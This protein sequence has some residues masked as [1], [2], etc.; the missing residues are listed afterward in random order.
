LRPIEEV[1]V[2]IEP[3]YDLGFKG[4]VTAPDGTVKY[5]PYSSFPPNAKPY[6]LKDS[7]QKAVFHFMKLLAA[8]LKCTFERLFDLDAFI[9]ATSLTRG[10]VPSSSRG[11]RPVDLYDNEHFVTHVIMNMRMGFWHVLHALV[12]I[13]RQWVPKSWGWVLMTP[14]RSRASST[15]VRTLVGLYIEKIYSF[16]APEKMSKEGL[17]NVIQQMNGIEAFFTATVRKNMA[18]D[19]VDGMRTDLPLDVYKVSV[20]NALEVQTR[21]L[22]S[23]I[24]VDTYETLTTLASDMPAFRMRN[25]KNP[26]FTVREYDTHLENALAKVAPLLAKER[27]IAGI[28]PSLTA[29]P[30]AERLV[31]SMKIIKLRHLIYCLHVMTTRISGYATRPGT[32]ALVSS[33]D[34]LVVS[35]ASELNSIPYLTNDQLRQR[36]QSLVEVEEED[37]EDV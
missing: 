17:H 9:T 26:I 27:T 7:S 37:Q 22:D 12:M 33:L 13:T 29:L 16:N 21:W 8:D 5:Q 14:L 4:K 1:T 20:A 25:A 34:A 19:F 30:L 36:R 6:V 3:E 2:K 24:V 23:K 18:D 35:V 11:A 32:I 10:S 15:Q 31:L 28:I